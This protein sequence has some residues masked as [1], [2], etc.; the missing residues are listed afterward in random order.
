[1]MLL[2]MQCADILQPDVGWCGGITELKRIADLAEK[3]GV[4]VIPH[5]SSVYAYHFVITRHNSPFSEFLMMAP[6]ADRVIPMFSPLLLDEP[7]PVKGR[8]RLPETPGFGVRLNPGCKLRR[9]YDRSLV[10]V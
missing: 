2:E 3:A 8:L 9:P 7:V 1:R 6:E 10:G 4:L 5:G